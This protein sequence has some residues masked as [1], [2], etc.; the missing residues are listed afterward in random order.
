MISVIVYGRNDSHGYNLHKR[1]A[2]SLNCIAE[3]L[4]HADDEILFVDYNT[5][6][7]F[8]SFPEAIADTLTAR[9]RRLLRV[10][11]VRPA[12]HRR[13]AHLSH[14]VVL[15]P[16]A[17]NVALRRANP[18]N[19]W[20]LSTNSDMIFVPHT[21]GSLSA[22][23]AGL[24]DG[25]YHLPRMELP[26]SLWEGLDRRDPVACMAR[27]GDWA[28]RFHLNEVVESSF[29][30]IRYD[31]P[32][33][34][35]L[36]LR[37]DLHE[38]DGF[39]EEMLLGW[40]VD[41]N[42]GQRLELRRGPTGTL[43]H[44]L[45]GYH[46]EHTRQV[47]AT[48]RPDSVQNDLH[49]FALDIAE[50]R[51][52]AQAE[53]W[54]LAGEAVEEFR[55]D[56]ARLR[57]EAALSAAIV[58]PQETPSRV[59]MASETWD[60]IGY[61]ACHALPFLLDP[62]ASYPPGTRIGWFGARA[63]L[64]RLF[65]A[66]AGPLGFTTQVAVAEGAEW[67]GPVL[68][69]GAHW[70]ERAAIGADADVLV[71]DFGLPDGCT[72]LDAAE[73][74]PE[75]EF[76]AAGFRA[77]V[78]AERRLAQAKGA[79]WVP[80]RFIAVNA[81]H[82]RFE[83]LLRDHINAPRAPLGT[84]IRQGILLH[85]PSEAIEVQSLLL[86]GSAGRREGAAIHPLPGRRGHVQYGPYL[87]LPAGHW[88]FEQMFDPGP[89]MLLPGPLKLRAVA[90]EQVLASRTLMLSGLRRRLLR[91]DFVVPD[92]ADDAPPLLLQIVTTSI[93]LVHGRLTGGRLLASAPV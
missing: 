93:G 49:R 27:V 89:G 65:T 11:R 92:Q 68:P 74:P 63:D 31:G 61:D 2:L 8:P 1:A 81:I 25:S 41:F 73:L 43:E 70:A 20:V 87:N 26:E 37:A 22:I 30:S 44:A 6:D 53:S 32:G 71:F 36:M 48:H 54:G 59:M 60:R 64:L 76:V 42:I 85:H 24:P 58:E 4:D 7:D 18:A 80:R 29:S 51:L 91:L 75:L 38:I 83:T 13:F 9:A 19:R 46:C 47:T 39:D 10:L 77:M 28:R 15:E 17:R 3:L 90:G 12:Q 45:F 33:D 78:R 72:G 50:A 56:R 35:Q 57:Y 84:R 88:R 52:P 16:V 62:L 40:H 34:F 14:L 21:P 67:L 66:A 55:L 69:A 79:G 82:N 23:V 5:P 86:A